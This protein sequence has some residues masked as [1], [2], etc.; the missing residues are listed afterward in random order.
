M[1]LFQHTFL[2]DVSECFPR[3]YYFQLFQED[4]RRQQNRIW[5]KII[6]IFLDSLPKLFEF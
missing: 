4:P 1:R 5:Q 2:K 6:F 3:L